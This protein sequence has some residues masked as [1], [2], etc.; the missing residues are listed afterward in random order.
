MHRDTRVSFRIYFVADLYSEVG[1]VMMCVQA[2][3]GFLAI[4]KFVR[5]RG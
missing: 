4:T 3:M 1:S 5:V 2:V